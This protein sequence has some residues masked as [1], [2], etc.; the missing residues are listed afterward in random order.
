MN[1]RKWGR[2][3][4]KWRKDRGYRTRDRTL[5]GKDIILKYMSTK[6]CSFIKGRMNYV[7]LARKVFP[8]Q[9]LPDGALPIF[10]K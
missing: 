1:K 7:S 8:V 4:R 6:I 3:V 5:K 2:I 10:H 9:Q